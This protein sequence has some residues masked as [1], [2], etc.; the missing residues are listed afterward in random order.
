MA[1]GDFDLFPQDGESREQH[2]HRFQEAMLGE[3]WRLRFQAN[4]AEYRALGEEL[5]EETDPDKIVGLTEQRGASLIGGLGSGAISLWKDDI[6]A[7]R[8]QFEADFG[9]QGE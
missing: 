8:Q 7:E 2:E 6:L 9:Q 3:D 4:G 1:S 5:T